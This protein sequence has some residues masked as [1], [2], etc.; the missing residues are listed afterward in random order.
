MKN[1]IIKMFLVLSVAF[2][3]FISSF[4]I[5]NANRAE[6]KVELLEKRVETLENYV[7]RRNNLRSPLEYEILSEIKRA[8]N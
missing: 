4:A 7:L 6:Q 5:Q 2:C 3:I 8:E 1:E